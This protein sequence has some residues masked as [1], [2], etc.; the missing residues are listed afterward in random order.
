MT[1]LKM[2]K[3][4][5]T[6]KTILKVKQQNT[7]MTTLAFLLML[8]IIVETITILKIHLKNLMQDGVKIVI[9][10]LLLISKQDLITMA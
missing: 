10:K 4:I 1:T 6:I 8:M 3:E 9:L 5:V 7:A 2:F